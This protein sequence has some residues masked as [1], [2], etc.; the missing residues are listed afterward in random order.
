MI[1]RT[2]RVLRAAGVA[3]GL[4]F[5]VVGVAR[6]QDPVDLGQLA[7]FIQWGGVAASVVVFA[8]ALVLLRGLSHLSASL[9]QRFVSRRPTIQK[10]ESASR[11]IV[12]LIAIVIAGRLSLRMDATALTVVGG[13]LAFAV[14][15]A[16]R[17]LVAAVIAGVT[18]MFDRPFQVGD[19]VEYAGQYGDVI[20]IGLR[21]VRMNTLDHNVITIPNNKVLTDVTSSGNYGALEMQ[22]PFTLFIGPDQDVELAMT[23]IQEACLTSPYAFL[24]RPAPVLATQVLEGNFVLIRITARPYVF[25][26][27][28]EKSFE[29]DVTLRVRRAFREHGITTPTVAIAGRV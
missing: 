22:V 13:G 1:P 2:A 14:G 6:A 15:F 26:A 24:D 4:N 21:S 3:A 8:L 20:K 25:E 17:D 5:A 18:I 28:H 12:Y 23:L 9:C 16:M 29:T 11:F 7:G 27:V 19:R 10:I